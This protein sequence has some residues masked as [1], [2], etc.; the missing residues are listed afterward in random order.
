[1]TL[2]LSLLA[3][4]IAALDER[5]Q[6]LEEKV[7]GGPGPTGGLGIRFADVD[8]KLQALNGRVMAA[9]ADLD[10]RCDEKIDETIKTLAELQETVETLKRS[11]QARTDTRFA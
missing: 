2:D 1:M 4:Q 3:S 9:I 7:Y 5:L 10:K 8:E 6:R 11:S